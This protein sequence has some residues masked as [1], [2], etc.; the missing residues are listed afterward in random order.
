MNGNIKLETEDV[1]GGQI[2]LVRIIGELDVVSS[3]SFREKIG[4]YIESGFINLIFDLENLRFLDSVGNL[5]LVNVYMKAKKAG[6]EVSCFGINE[7]IRE[8][9]DAVG[10]AKIIRIYDSFD[11]AL[12][13]GRHA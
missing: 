5:S 4:S 11:E 10:I 12:R 6:G 1:A 9:L 3:G 8:I 2:K 7:N 13:G